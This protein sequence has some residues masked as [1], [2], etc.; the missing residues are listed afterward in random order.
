MCNG[1]ELVM[2]NSSEILGK[3]RLEGDRIVLRPLEDS[4]ASTLYENVKEYEMARWLINI[5]HP[6]PEDGA[7]EFINKSKELMEK[8]ESYEMAI[9]F[10]ETS[11]V[12]G[13][14]SFC[15][16]D[17]KHRNAELGYW[18]AK[19][20]RNKGIATEAASALLAYGFKKLN[21]ERIYAKCFV[22][23]K[24]SKRIMEKLGMDYEGT[25]RHEVFKEDKFIDTI[26]FSILRE[27]WLKGQDE[28]KSK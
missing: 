2:E 7:L 23:N 14:M 9:E 17:Q 13:V 6:Y 4:D 24:P 1:G 26:F 16:V 22:D 27:D 8:G 15:K 18:V 28:V 11:E 10:K 20:H 5:P 12:I 25:F 3:P 21:L 19:D